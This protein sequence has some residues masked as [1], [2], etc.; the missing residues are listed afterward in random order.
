MVFFVGLFIIGAYANEVEN[1]VVRFII[2][3]S[4]VSGSIV[5]VAELFV[6]IKCSAV[7]FQQL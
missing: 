3:F 1:N 2:L 4:F 6:S 7:G 5:C